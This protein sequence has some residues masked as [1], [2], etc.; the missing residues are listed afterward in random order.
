M[1][2]KSLASGVCIQIVYTGQKMIHIPG[3]KAQD[4]EKF[5]HITQNGTQFKTNELPKPVWLGG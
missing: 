2:T 3:E 5:H 1:A 4:G